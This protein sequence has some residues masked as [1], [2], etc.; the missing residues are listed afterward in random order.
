MTTVGNTIVVIT[1]EGNVFGTDVS[2]DHLSDVYQMNLPAPVISVRTEDFVIWPE[3]EVHGEDFTGGGMV[4]LTIAGFPKWPTLTHRTRAT[5]DGQM[6]YFESHDR[7]TLSH[8]A[9]LPPVQVTARDETT[10]RIATGKT[11]AEPF[12]SRFQ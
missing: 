9:I 4:E 3:L 7:V 5:P 12:A 1:S 8:D 2:G 10:G 6:S 11:S